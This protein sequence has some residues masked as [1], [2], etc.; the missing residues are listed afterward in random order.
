MP[1]PP[2]APLRGFRRGAPVLRCPRYPVAS[3]EL[4]LASDAIAGAVTYPV[5]VIHAVDNSTGQTVCG[6][7]LEGL[8][9]FPDVDFAGIRAPGRCRLCVL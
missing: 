6:L 7:P 1:S 3:E 8:F 9:E 2:E 4:Q 5:G